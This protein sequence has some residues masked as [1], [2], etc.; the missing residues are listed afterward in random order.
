MSRVAV[1]LH[2]PQLGGATTALLRVL[3]ELERRGFEFSFWVPGRGAAE[4]EL[5]RLGYDVASAERLMRF[6]LPSLR[7]PPGAVRRARSVPAYLRSVRA[8][9][10]RTE[11][12]LIHL[13]TLLALPEL[14]ARPG[15]GPPVLLYAHEVLPDGP[16]GTVA[17]RMARQ[18]DVVVAVSEAVAAPLRRRGVET[19]V[20]NNGVVPSARPHEARETGALVVGTLGTVCRRKG[21]DIFLAATRL[22]RRQ[23][24]DVRFRIVGEAVVGGER[25]WAERLLEEAASEGV[26]HRV[27]VDPFAELSEWDVFVLPSRMDPFPLAVLEAMAI[28]L[29]VVASRVG[30]I[31]E[32]VGEEAALLVECEDV[33]GTAAAIVRLVD[34]PQLRSRLGSAARS[35]VVDRFTLE[36]QA[37]GLA[38]AYQAAIGS[39]R[40]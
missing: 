22:V 11:A 29:P 4:A 40:R 13:N 3:P 31:P 25:A 39:G 19:T 1:V 7:Q 2:E 6:S 28:G 8:W 36:R 5:R 32:E 9:L 17:G 33:D 26:E 21:S 23:R 30:G 12:E 27:G 34:S 20:V 18:A 10:S 37:E 35:R 38:H 14:T 16:K 15:G 24:Q